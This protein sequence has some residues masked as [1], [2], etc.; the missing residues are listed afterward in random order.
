[1]DVK[2]LQAKEIRAFIMALENEDPV[3]L[4]LKLSKEKH[5]L[6]REIIAQVKG[7][8]KAA[9]KIPSMLK[10]GIIFPESVSLEQCSSDLTAEFKTELISGETVIDLSA[11]FGIDA[12]HFSK[13]FDK[14]ILVEPAK[15]L[16]EIVEINFKSLG[17]SNGEFYNSTAEEFLNTKKLQ[18][19]WVYIDPS[20]R[21]ENNQKLHKLSDCSPNLPE[22]LPKIFT[23][24]SNVLL[25]T[26]PL[27]DIHAAFAELECV[28]K[29]IVLAVKNECKEVLYV[30]EKD[31]QGG[32]SVDAVNLEG[33]TKEKQ[34]FSFTFEEELQTVSEFSVP[35]KYLYEPNAAVLK[36]GAFKLSGARFN[37]K[38]LHQHS[39]LFTSHQLITDF[40]GKV[41]EIIGT[42]KPDKKSISK[43]LPEMKANAAIRNFKSTTA[44][45]I[46]KTG[47]REGGNF[48]VFF[49]TDI[50][51]NGVAVVCRRLEI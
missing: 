27:L 39:H 2:A 50:N 24:A 49:T 42:V 13:K 6:A 29:V 25:K 43:L 20:R 16:S 47:L 7:R 9:K 44:E 31:Y 34:S 30:L 32:V 36:S 5:P 11:G 28:K 51:N 38:K 40:P 26:S 22:L 8:Q 15:E 48:M 21:T 23:L 1:V 17:I 18:P 37:L 46:K 33:S 41:F 3:K 45:M 19:D 10:E 12:A 4:A 35:E 14:V